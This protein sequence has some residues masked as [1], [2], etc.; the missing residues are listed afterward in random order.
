MRPEEDGCT[1]TTAP[2]SLATGRQAEPGPVFVD[3]KHVADGAWYE[4]CGKP[5]QPQ[6][7]YFVSGST[8]MYGAALY[9]HAGLRRAAP[10]RG[11]PPAWPLIYDDLCSAGY[12]PL[13][14]PAGSCSTRL[15]GREHLDPRTEVPPRKTEEAVI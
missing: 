7:R 5:F 12:N 1:R 15:R 4:A 11:A 8:K 13:N 14:T 3:N 9:R 2:S 10:R 6:V